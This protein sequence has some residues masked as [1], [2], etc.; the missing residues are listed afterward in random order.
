MRMPDVIIQVHKFKRANMGKIVVLDSSI[1][2]QDRSCDGRD[3]NLFVKWVSLKLLVWHIPWIVF[4]EVISKGFYEGKNALVETRKSLKNLG[5]IGQKDSIR[6]Q[7]EELT[8]QVS[9]LELHYE[10][11]NIEY[12]KSFFQKGIIDD[13]DSSSSL[14]VM[15][16]Y[17]AGAKPFPKPKSRTDIPDAF[18]YESLK[19]LSKNNS[20]SFICADNNLRNKCSEIENVQCYESLRSFENSEYG[21]LIKRQYEQMEKNPF[22]LDLILGHKKEILD[23]IEDDVRGDM[24]VDYSEGFANEY[25]PDGGEGYLRDI[26]EVSSFEINES[27][28]TVVD[29]MVYIPIS[30]KCQF[31]V[32]YCIN[33]IDLSFFSNRT[34][35]FEGD[36]FVREI[37]NVSFSFTYSLRRDELCEQRLNLIVPEKVDNLILKPIYKELI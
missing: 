17:F 28:I 19:T 2:N 8:C 9:Q 23:R 21:S 27:E 12:W 7:L 3:M 26:P 11:K 35:S 6:K 31:D 15:K 10:E 37:F 1:I 14:N 33:S 24:F 30:V 36:D 34:V 32:E 5:K 13:F 29:E 18:I 4:Q 25:F 16:A 22:K 20:I